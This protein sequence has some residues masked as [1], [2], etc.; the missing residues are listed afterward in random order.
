MRD[1][2]FTPPAL[3]VAR[4]DTIEWINRDIVPHTTTALD[5]A[6]NSGNV[7]AGGRF[8]FVAR[9]A[10]SHRYVCGYH[11]DMTGRIVVR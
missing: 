3:T 4:G 1:L 8:R 10:G 11:P 7:A 2:R 5:S 6:W 9:R